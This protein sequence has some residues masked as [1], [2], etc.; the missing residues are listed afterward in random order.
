MK[1]WEKVA[2]NAAK[3]VDEAVS[4]LRK[5]NATVLKRSLNTM[6]IINSVLGPLDIKNLG[7]TL[8]RE[9]VMCR[10]LLK[11]NSRSVGLYVG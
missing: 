5:G 2:H 4:I 11:S 7:F 6:G 3:T 1:T 8:M 9:H 10:Q